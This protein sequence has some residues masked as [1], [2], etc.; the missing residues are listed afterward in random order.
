[1]KSVI[2]NNKTKNSVKTMHQRFFFFFF[3][4]GGRSEGG[5]GA[6]LGLGKW[7]LKIWKPSKS[8]EIVQIL[9]TELKCSRLFRQLL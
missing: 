6:D 2:L 4:E 3:L 8:S 9:Q 1:M 7:K 5:G